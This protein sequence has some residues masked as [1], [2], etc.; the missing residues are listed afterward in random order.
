MGRRTDIDNLDT[1][2]TV[3]KCVFFGHRLQF[4]L[5]AILCG[6]LYYA[7]DRSCP[8]CDVPTLS[9]VQD[10]ESSAIIGNTETL[11]KPRLLYI[12]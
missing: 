9:Y 12:E 1:A 7:A 8:T 2:C 3:F 4:Q 5:I 11:R 6:V 10:I